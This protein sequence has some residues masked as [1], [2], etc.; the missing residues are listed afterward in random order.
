MNN[1][2]ELRELVNPVFNTAKACLEFDAENG[3]TDSKLLL[4]T[5]AFESTRAQNAEKMM[6]PEL[7]AKVRHITPVFSTY[8][9]SRFHSVNR[10]I[11]SMPDRTIVDLPCGYTA[12]GIKMAHTGRT[13]YGFDLPA[14]IDTIA[15]AAAKING[16]NEAIHYAAVDATNYE[17]MEAP[18]SGLTAPL[19][20]TTEGLLMYLTQPEIEAVFGNVRRLLQKHGGSWILV[21]RTYYIN[22]QRIADVILCEDPEAMGMFKAIAAKGA[23]TMADIKTNNNLFFQGNDAEVRAFIHRMGFELHE[24]CMA[25]YLPDRLVSLDP[26]PQTEADVRDVFKTMFFW[27]LTVREDESSKANVN[28]PFALKTSF[29]GGLFTVI[30]QGRMD[31]ITAPELLQRFQAIPGKATAIEVDVKNMAYVSSAGLRVLLM[32]YKSLEDKSRFK[33]TGVSEEVREILEVTGFDQFL[34]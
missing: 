32:M 30:I 9:E 15:P 26:L 7:L 28:L 13:Y 23:G 10:L 6:P 17:T 18:L 14:V 5:L 12:R 1:I 34:L 3:D 25:D 27:E 31:T 24:I 2:Q 33:M 8:V 4:D 16:S 11:A 20:I 21:D 19:L 29:A 22:E